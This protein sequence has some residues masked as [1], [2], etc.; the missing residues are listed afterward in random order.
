MKIMQTNVLKVIAKR[1]EFYKS[2]FRLI[3]KVLLISI[4]LNVILFTCLWYSHKENE[5]YFLAVNDQGVVKSLDLPKKIVV[6]DDMLVNWVSLNTTK[7]YKFDFL[8]YKEQILTL[9][10]LFTQQGWYAFN[11]AFKETVDQVVDHKMVAKAALDGVPIITAAG[12]IAGVSSWQVQ[13]PVLVTFS[14]GNEVS[15][16][17]IILKLTIQKNSRIQD[18]AKGHYFGIAQIIQLNSK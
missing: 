11:E 5:Y 13:V 17:H 12:H 3:I 10:P 16:N 1:A 6:T 8:N 14:Q 15:N 2:N 4:L 7:L 9:K 18:L